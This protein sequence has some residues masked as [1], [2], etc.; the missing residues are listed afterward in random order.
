[1][2]SEKGWGENNKRDNS[3][4]SHS[5]G[6]AGASGEWRERERERETKARFSR[7]FTAAYSDLY[8]FKPADGQ[9]FNLSSNASGSAPTGRVSAVLALAGGRLF[10]Y[11]DDVFQGIIIILFHF[12]L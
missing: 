6:A 2:K 3:R 4:E 10:V 1:M 8:R 12:K 9:W 5:Y 11:G 7:A